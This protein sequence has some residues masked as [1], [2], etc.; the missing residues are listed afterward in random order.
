MSTRAQIQIEGSDV[1]IYKHCDG[2][3]DGVLPTLRPFVAAFFKHRGWD[4]AYFTARCLAA[5]V[6]EAEK[7]RAAWR[8]QVERETPA[9]VKSY[10]FDRPD[11]L[12]FG[13]DTSI[14]GDIAYFYH[15]AK[16]GTITVRVPTSVS[17][18]ALDAW[19]HHERQGGR[20]STASVI[21]SMHVQKTIK[22]PKASL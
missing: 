8:K 6:A 2:Y 1:L 9:L 5:F 11:F 19:E 16:D 4:P 15:V 12:S 20:I 18:A 10:G 13:V 3:P 22:L 14:H 17:S 21:A 7:S